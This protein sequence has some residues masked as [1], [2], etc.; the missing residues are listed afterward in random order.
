M[1]QQKAIMETL[2]EAVANKVLSD[3][4]APDKTVAINEFLK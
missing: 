2:L 3:S 4:V 1:S